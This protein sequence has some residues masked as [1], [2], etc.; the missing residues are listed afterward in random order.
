MQYS[1]WEKVQPTAIDEPFS[2]DY[3][4]MLNWPELKAKKRDDY[5]SVHGRGHGKV[6]IYAF[7]SIDFMLFK[8]LIDCLSLC[9]SMI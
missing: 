6:I 9:S 3:P 2:C 5:D 8:L 7:L 1:Y 4:L